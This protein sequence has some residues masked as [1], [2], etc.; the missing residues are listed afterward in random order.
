MLRSMLDSGLSRRRRPAHGPVAG[1]LLTSTN[2]HRAVAVLSTSGA[3]NRCIGVQASTEELVAAG[4]A[5]LQK[6]VVHAL[7]IAGGSGG[8]APSLQAAVRET[9]TSLIVCAC[10]YPFW[11]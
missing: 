10:S 2:L 6:R 8:D 7:Q 4:A 5:A 11:S 9:T 1:A 3:P